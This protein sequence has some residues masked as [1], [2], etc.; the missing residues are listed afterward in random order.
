MH[1]N[2]MESDFY[3]ESEEAIDELDKDA[4][5]I[6]ADTDVQKIMEEEHLSP[7]LPQDPDN[8][9]HPHV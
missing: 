8:H 6:T 2:G 9:H 3:E 1:L 7:S 4:E 5:T